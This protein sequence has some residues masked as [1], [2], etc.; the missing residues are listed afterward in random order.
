MSFIFSD[1]V[2]VQVPRNITFVKKL[3]HTRNDTPII[4]KFN[5]SLSVIATDNYQDVLGHLP[6]NESVT[7]YEPLQDKIW[8][9]WVPRGC[10]MLLYFDDFDLES[11]PNCTKDFFSIQDKRNGTVTKYCGGISN[12][13]N[14]TNSS[15]IQ[16]K[17]R[18]VQL[19]FHSDSS[20]TKKGLR[21]TFCFQN[22]K[23]VTF[24]PCSCNINT[25]KVARRRRRK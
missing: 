2:P 10:R 14:V 1:W 3:P 6:N 16:I 20:V 15:Q 19:T 7:P 5:S 25:T 17:R 18:R 23:S 8:Q 13:P 9:I 12:L 11:T 22:R 21:A 24:P 4:Q